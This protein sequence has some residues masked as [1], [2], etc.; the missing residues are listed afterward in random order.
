MIKNNNN[1]QEY[2]LTD[3]LNILASNNEP[4]FTHKTTDVNQIIG[5]NTIEQLNK[6]EG[7]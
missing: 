4:V 5:I 6:A 7:C 3:V 1:Q 2:Y